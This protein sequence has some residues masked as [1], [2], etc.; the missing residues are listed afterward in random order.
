M[1]NIKYRVYLSESGWTGWVWDGE[2]AGDLNA[3]ENDFIQKMQVRLS[4]APDKTNVIY[5][6]YLTGGWGRTG[7]VSGGQE[8]GN[9][10]EDVYIHIVSF[11]LIN[12]SEELSIL[13]RV[14]I[15]QE[16]WTGWA[17]DEQ[18]IGHAASLKGIAIKIK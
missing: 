5:T 12:N 16:G 18:Y 6:A 14:Y 8:C 11:Q 1:A 7:W 4:D 17:R 13:Y 9:A 10:E 15:N 3:T 2:T